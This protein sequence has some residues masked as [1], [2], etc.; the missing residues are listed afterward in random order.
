MIISR[1]I[2]V[3]GNSNISVFLWMINIPLCVYVYIYIYMCVCTYIYHIFF[4]HISVSEHFVSFLVLAIINGI[5][6]S[7]WVH[8]S[9]DLE[10]SPDNMHRSG[11]AI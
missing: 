10:F 11:I 3:A 4:V 1:S 7:I 8:I 9:F 5:V 2:H 6:M